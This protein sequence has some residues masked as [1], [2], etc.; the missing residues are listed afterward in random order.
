MLKEYFKQRRQKAKHVSRKKINKLIEEALT[1]QDSL[2][3]QISSLTPEERA[4][5]QEEPFKIAA[6][7]AGTR[8][9]IAGGLGG[10]L[11]AGAYNL[12]HGGD[13]T[14]PEEVLLPSTLAALAMGRASALGGTIG[15][16]FNNKDAAKLS[17]K[18]IEQA[19]QKVKKEHGE[20][21]V[22]ILRKQGK[23]NLR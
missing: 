12:T 10:L 19:L 5:L 1:R 16:Y 2:A 8:M 9:G 21:L 13:I 20:Y 15:Q 7:N 11:G 23:Q 18:E 4:R 3:V 6:K 14:N 22:D 17:P